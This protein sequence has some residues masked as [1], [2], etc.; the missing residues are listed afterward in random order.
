MDKRQGEVNRSLAGKT[1]PENDQS[2]TQHSKTSD[3]QMEEEVDLYYT[4]DE[5]RIY[6]RPTPKRPSDRAV[7]SS[8]KDGKN[9]TG[10]GRSDEPVAKKTRGPNV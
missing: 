9:A 5:G 1:A 8:S 7:S 10:A 6:R 4:D 3:F 2:A